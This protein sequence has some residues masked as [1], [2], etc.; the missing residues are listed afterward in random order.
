MVRLIIHQY[1]DQ[2]S[3]NVR[4]AAFGNVGTIITFRIGGADA[5]ILVKEFEPTFEVTDLVNIPKFNIYL[6]LMIDGVASNAFSAAT[7][8]P[9]W[10]PEGNREAIIKMTR[11]IY[12]NPRE[13]TEKNILKWS[14][15]AEEDLDRKEREGDMRDESREIKEQAKQ[16][17]PRGGGYQGKMPGV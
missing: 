11:E 5:E 6:K 15:M 14:G 16:M 9:E 2:L 10:K 17:A 3:E 7:L 13:E 8:P 1:I 4:Y 12:S